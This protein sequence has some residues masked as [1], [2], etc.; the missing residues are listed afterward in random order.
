M[1]RDPTCA[2]PCYAGQVKIILPHRYQRCGRRRPE[3]CANGVDRLSRSHVRALERIFLHDRLVGRGAD[4]PDVR[5]RHADRRARRRETEGG[6][7]LYTSPVV[8][9]L[10]VVL[11]V[12]GGSIAPA[13]SA[14]VFGTG[15]GV[16]AL[17]GLAIGIRVRSASRGHGSA[18]P[19]YAASTCAGTG[20]PRP[21]CTRGSPPQRSRLLWRE[22]GRDDGRRQPHGPAPGQHPRRMGFGDLSCAAR[23][24][25]PTPPTGGSRV[26]ARSAQFAGHLD[27]R[28]AESRLREH[29]LRSFIPLGREQ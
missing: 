13:M 22:L 24:S 11:V 10:G 27:H 25:R 6:K 29:L 28:P 4:R 23:R 7:H 8:W 21:R 26:G 20:S 3:A 1:P 15:C 19:E 17:L 14:R 5:R 9:H 12:S 18:G 16:L 2:Q